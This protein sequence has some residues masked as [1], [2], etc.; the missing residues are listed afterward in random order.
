MRCLYKKNMNFKFQP[1]LGSY[2]L[3]LVNVLLL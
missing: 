2:S 1:T 3:V